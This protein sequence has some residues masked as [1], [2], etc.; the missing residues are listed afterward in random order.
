VLVEI[1]DQQMAVSIQGLKIL[2][3]EPLINAPKAFFD[4]VVSGG[5]ARFRNLRVWEAVPK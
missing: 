4:F 3:A 2:G 5:S 1:V